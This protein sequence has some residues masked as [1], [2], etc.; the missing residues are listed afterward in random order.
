MTQITCGD[1]IKGVTI[2]VPIPPPLDTAAGAAV[3]P[4]DS[5]GASDVSK[6]KKQPSYE[7]VRGIV[8]RLLVDHH[9]TPWVSIQRLL[10]SKEA[11]HFGVPVPS[12]FDFEYELLQQQTVPPVWYRVTDIIDRFHLALETKAEFRKKMKAGELPNQ[13]IYFIRKTESL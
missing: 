12:S 8:D 2:K 1:R 7:L 9:M 4:T 6:S 11:R 13:N 3:S 10:T 5:A